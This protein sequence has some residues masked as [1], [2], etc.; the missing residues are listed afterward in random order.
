MQLP[1]PQHLKLVRQRVLASLKIGD[2]VPVAI[3]RAEADWAVRV[4]GRRVFAPSPLRWKLYRQGWEARLDRLSREYGVD[5]HVRLGPDSVILDIGAN[6]GEFAHVAAR[7]GARAYCVEPDP[8][9]FRCLERNIEGLANAS[10]HDAL[11]WN[12]EEEIAFGLAPARAD[13][14]V[15]AG[16]GPRVMRRATTIEQFARANAITRI[17]LLKCDAEG[18]EPEVLEGIGSFFPQIA[19]FA[20]DTGA[21]R[22]GLRTHRECRAILEMN[23]FRVVDEKIGTRLM[24]YGL[25][26][27]PL[28]PPDLPPPVKRSATSEK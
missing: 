8:S 27:T 13:S 11:I 12:R 2:N 20:L 22:N 18:A 6:V 19:A 23:G 1:L 4:D 28:Q 16:T 5:R 24:T 14:S 9:A 7:Y 26:P 21:E 3:E 17:D 10:A 15:F 25:A